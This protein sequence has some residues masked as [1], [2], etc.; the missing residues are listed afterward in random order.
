MNDDIIRR[1]CKAIAD[2]PDKI[3]TLDELGVIAGMSPHH[4]Q[5]VFKRATG[6]SPH[7]YGQ[8][9]RLDRFRGELQNGESVSSALYG[10]GFGSPSRLYEDV[11]SRLG[12]T[13]ASY[14]KGGAGARIAFAL[15]LSVLGRI[16]VA[17]T[18]KGVCFVG[19]G[20]GDD[21]LET[22]LR[23]EFP[24][25][26]IKRD[27]GA[28]ATRLEAVLEHLTGKTARLDLPLDIRATAFQWQV[29]QALRAIPQGETLTYGD[30]AARLGRP[31]AARAVGRACAT[32]PVSLI[33]PCHRA[34]GVGA[35][36][37]GYRWG[38]ERKKKLLATEKK[39]IRQTV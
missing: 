32:N 27:D 38:V 21:Y 24:A 28:L 25:A 17:A 23:G 26:E 15:G 37:T 33:V 31:G 18:E 7:K 3:P 13:P 16:I 5:R 30:I 35:K 12:M 29:W 4:L 22:E 19:L 34:V 36:P 11:G 39:R 10:A 9:L 20:D 8:S 6:L 1:V 2:S 14:A